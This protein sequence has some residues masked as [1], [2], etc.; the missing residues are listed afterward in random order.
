MKLSKQ[1]R[2]KISEQILSHIFYSF[3]K[4]LFTSEIAQEIVRD[5]EFVKNLLFELKEKGLIV[6]IRKNEKGRSF[7][8]RLKWQLSSKA[9]EAYQSKVR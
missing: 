8:R 9:Y 6:A 4:Q 1:K 2:D 5:E 3:P 7:I